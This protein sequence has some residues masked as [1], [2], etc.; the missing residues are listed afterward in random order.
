M[1]HVTEKRNNV[2]GAHS[3]DF[4]MS[5]SNVV[6]RAINLINEAARVVVQLVGSEHKRWNDDMFWGRRRRWV[7]SGGG[8]EEE[9]EEGEAVPHR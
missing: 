6:E 8:C 2:H 9:P 4:F 5:I 7:A 1:S 3:R